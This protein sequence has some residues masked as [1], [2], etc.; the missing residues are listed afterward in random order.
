M[1]VLGSWLSLAQLLSW[2]LATPASTSLA[3]A[4]PGLTSHLAWLSPYLD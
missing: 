2:S 1:T 3:A 4:L